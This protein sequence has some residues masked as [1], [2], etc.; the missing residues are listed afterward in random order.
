MR[1]LSSPLLARLA[2]GAGALVVT[3]GMV[4]PFQGAEEAFVPWDKAAH[5][6]AFYSLTS[7]LFVAFPKRRR[8]DLAF[9]AVLG[10]SA[11]EVAQ[12]LSGRDAELGDV[13]ADAIG[14][15][16]VLAPMYIEQIRAGARAAL[17]GRAP[18][19]RR[20]PWYARLFARPRQTASSY[21]KARR[22][23][24]PATELSPRLLPLP[25]PRP[26]RSPPGAA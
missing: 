23:R 17:A 10:G 2:L 20:A 11:T 18:V 5:F 13:L 1:T 12:L 21:A 24:R 3:I 22:V 8:L 15:A 16:A 9:L 26:E 25:A 4:G 7:A 14:A 19:D 6:I